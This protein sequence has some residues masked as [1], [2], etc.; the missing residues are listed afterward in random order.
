MKKRG[1]IASVVF[2]IVF[3]AFYFLRD[4]QP[5]K[6][7]YQRDEGTI[8]GTIYH[9]S[10][11]YPENL[12]QQIKEELKRFDASM[13]TFNKN[14]IISRINRNDSTV[15]ADEWFIRVFNT[16]RDVSA[17]TEGSFDMTVAPLVNAWGFGFKKSDQ[18]TPALIDSIRSFVGQEK[19][20]LAG[21]KVIKTD[22]RVM[23]DASAIAKG[24]ACDVIGE[25][26]TKKGIRNY[27]VEI[28]GEVSAKGKNT[29]GKC[30]R[31]G[32]NK[33][34]EDQSASAGEIQEIINLCGGGMATSGNYRNFYYKEGKRYAHTIDPRTGYPVE[35]SLL[36]ATVIAPSCM[37]AD[38]FATAF[39]VLGLD[40]S[41]EIV[42]KNPEIDAYFI[43][44]DGS[45]ENAVKMSKGFEQYMKR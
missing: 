9:I 14:S 26:L 37:L 24:Y 27:M 21:K 18:V 4:N 1:F 33:P 39:M 12:H 36:S 10:Y 11:E 22:L 43:Y 45:E 44:A 5:A 42:E 17:A 32:I 29:S 38:A 8:F 40:K 35:H 6:G 41:M 20:R 16:G 13:S 25:L 2:L 28:G 30:W 34:I 23:L 15:E 31:I 7:I 19:I 3:M